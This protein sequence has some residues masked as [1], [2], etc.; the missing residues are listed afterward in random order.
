MDDLNEP[1]TYLQ[2]EVLIECKAFNVKFAEAGEDRQ[3]TMVETFFPAE[4]LG[5]MPRLG[6]VQMCAMY[7]SSICFD[8]FDGED[9]QQNVEE[10]VGYVLQ[11]R[12]VRI[13]EA[14]ESAQCL[15]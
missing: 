5:Q 10:F 1:P 13:D 14:K 3:F 8:G 15:N 7:L 12:K 4:I 6:M 11:L 2:A 9:L